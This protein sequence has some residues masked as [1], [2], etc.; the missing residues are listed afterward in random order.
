[1]QRVCQSAS[2]RVQPSRQG[3]AKHRYL[4]PNLFQAEAPDVLVFCLFVFG[5]ER[6]GSDPCKHSQ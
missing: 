3:V 6:E 4:Y 1:M 5:G 2:Q